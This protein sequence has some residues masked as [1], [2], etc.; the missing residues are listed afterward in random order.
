M[1]LYVN[2]LSIGR[3]VTSGTSGSLLYVNSSGQLAQDNSN[4]FWDD[5]NKRLGIGVTPL[6]QLHQGS[7]TRARHIIQGGTANTGTQGADTTWYDGTISHSIGFQQSLFGTGAQNFAIAAGSTN[8]IVFITNSAE[9]ARVNEYGLGAG[10]TPTNR[11]NTSLQTVNGLGFPATQVS[12]SDANTLDDY[13]EG[14]WTPSVG[15]SATYTSQSGTYT[16]IGNMVYIQGLLQI[17][18]LGTG[19]SSTI[20]GLPF[21]AS[22]SEPSSTIHVGIWT[23]TAVN[24]VY[25]ALTTSGST[26][27]FQGASAATASTSA[28]TALTNSTLVRFSGMYRT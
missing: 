5:T 7:A 2:V 8:P 4:L 3:T 18:S 15:G 24:Y 23:T 21:S 16:K 20:S 19:S 12:S 26:L 28:T 13:E 14:T 11:N 27:A 22:G 10:L 25:L 1:P 17:N 9:R 6:Y